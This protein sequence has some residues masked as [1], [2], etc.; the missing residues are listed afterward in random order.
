MGRLFGPRG[1]GQQLGS[2]WRDR[3]RASVARR[4]TVKSGAAVQYK[5]TIGRHAAKEITY[6]GHVTI[7]R[8]DW[9]RD[10]GSVGAYMPEVKVQVA[11]ETGYLYRIASDVGNWTYAHIIDDHQW[12][13]ITGNPDLN[14]E[15]KR[16]LL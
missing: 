10:V 7:F 6:W 16:D 2:K 12:A 5:E 3:A 14:D 8:D 9:S 15:T 4:G 13:G 1:A 11:S